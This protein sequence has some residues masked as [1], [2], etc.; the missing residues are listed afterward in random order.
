MQQSLAELFASDRAWFNTHRNET[1]RFRA[2]HPV[3]VASL[4]AIGHPYPLPNLT[5]VEL[6]KWFSDDDQ[7][8]IRTFHS[9]ECNI[10]N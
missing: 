8:R 4:Q 6:V 3:E 5:R 10:N 1:V 7:L 2:I 9:L